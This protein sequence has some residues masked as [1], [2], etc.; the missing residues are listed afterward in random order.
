MGDAD[1]LFGQKAAGELAQ[2]FLLLGRQAL[3]PTVA[4]Q[5]LQPE[6]GIDG[7]RW[8]ATPP[9]I[10]HRIPSFNGA[11]VS[12]CVGATQGRVLARPWLG[13]PG[14]LSRSVRDKAWDQGVRHKFLP[15]SLL[16][17]DRVRQ[18]SE[19]CRE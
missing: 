17:G 10:E 19:S 18:F 16:S 8:R 13:Q 14:H 1:G 12:S 3:Q 7:G 11:D 15:V 4:V 9:S 5:N 2:D 6:A